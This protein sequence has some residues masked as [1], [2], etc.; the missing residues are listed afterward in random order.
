MCRGCVLTTGWLL[1]AKR[2]APCP[3]VAM[4]HH[5][6]AKHLHAHGAALGY[7]ETQASGE[8]CELCR[9][10][11]LETLKLMI[12]CGAAIN[13]A[14]Y[15]RRTCLHLA[16]SEGNMRIVEYLIDSGADVNSTDRFVTPTPTPTPTPIPS[17][18]PRPTLTRWG[19]TPMIDAVREGHR[20]VADLL[21]RRGTQR[22]A[23]FRRA[24]LRD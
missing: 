3:Q 16:A 4:G 7:T 9:A 22:A 1:R 23:S 12:S 24:R 11:S 14:D 19:S 10:G 17:L 6:V 8:L 15:D 21:R 18:T 2:C 5:S 13:A 20:T